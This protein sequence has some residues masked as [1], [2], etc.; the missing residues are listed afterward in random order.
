[1]TVAMVVVGEEE[2][3]AYG[4]G[5]GRGREEGKATPATAGG[6]IVLPLSLASALLEMRFFPS[7]VRKANARMPLLFCTTL[8]NSI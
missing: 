7:H 2:E 5:A 4:R 3:D 8:L 6:G 1:M